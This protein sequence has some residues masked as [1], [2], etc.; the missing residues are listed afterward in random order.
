MLKTAEA[1]TPLH[2]DKI[3]DC[4]SDAILDACLEQDPNSRVAIETMGGHNIVTITG[5]LT[6]K[7]IINISDIVR[8]V[9]GNDYGIQTN[10]VQQSSEIA[11]GVDI[12][13]AGDQGVMVGY[14]CNDNRSLI[15]QELYLA[16]SLARFIFEIHL[17]D[18]K[19][20]VTIDGDVLQTIVVSFCQVSRD[21]LFKLVNLW[22]E[23]LNL[24]KP[25]QVYLNPAGDWTQG[26]FSADTGVTGRKLACDNYGP[27]IPIGGG[28]FSGKDATKVDRSGAYMARKIAVDLLKQHQA[29]EVLVKLAYSIGVA[30]PVMATA[31]IINQNNQRQ[32]I[33]I[34]NYDLTPQGI[35]DFLQLNRP[36]Y[37]QVAKWG[38]FGQGFIWDK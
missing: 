19:V 15:P 20:Q 33:V 3:C 1:V 4:I 17:Q 12:G 24:N 22:L 16:K 8:K 25:D 21:E 2:P 10:I 5:E 30:E 27:Q 7:A 18:G 36:Q 23:K 29:K 28:A 11:Q 37:S 38:S 6:T 26:G 14:A 35:I 9:I 13:G 32:Q 34:S 31:E